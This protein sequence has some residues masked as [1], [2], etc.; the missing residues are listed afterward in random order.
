MQGITVDL[1]GLV[2]FFGIFFKKVIKKA[3]LYLIFVLLKEQAELVQRLIDSTSLLE[4]YVPRCI[5][6]SSY[7]W[8]Q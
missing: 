3:L 2:V 5:E 1:D 7:L 4:M 8:R 6:V